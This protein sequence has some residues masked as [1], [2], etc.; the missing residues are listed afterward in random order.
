MEQ[1]KNY[2]TTEIGPM[3]SITRVILKESLGLTGAE[4]SFTR[5]PAGKAGAFI[6][7]HQRN[8]EIYLFISGKGLFWLDGEII[9]VKEGTAVRVSP[10]CQRRLKADDAE[11]LSYICIQADEGSLVQ[12]TRDDGIRAEFQPVWG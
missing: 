10:S 11:P 7:S 3:E 12:S 9:P 5:M 8:E 4:V 2:A 6:H 1:Q